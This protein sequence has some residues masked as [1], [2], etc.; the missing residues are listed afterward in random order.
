M[1]LHELVTK[2]RSYRRFKQDPAVE[3][4]QLEALADLARLTPSGGNLQPLK[5]AICCQ[6]AMNTQI[7]NTLRWAGYLRDWD[8]PG[9]GEQPTGYIVICRDNEITTNTIIDHGIAVQTMVLGAAEMGLGCCIMGTIDRAALRESL[10]LSR[11]YEILLVLALGTPGEE[12]TLDQAG[13]GDIKYWR[14][15]KGVHHV[16]KRPLD[17]ILLTWKQ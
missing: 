13:D 3:L 11:R 6:P 14:D 7:F 2:A 16:P 10:D 4:R 5:L 12:I 15:A 1:T 17:E 9:E 8:G